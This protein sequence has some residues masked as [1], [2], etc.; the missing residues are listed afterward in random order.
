M[1]STPLIHCIPKFKNV[2]QDRTI[3]WTPFF[4]TLFFFTFVLLT[5]PSHYDSFC[6]KFPQLLW[7]TCCILA[8]SVMHDFLS[9]NI[10][11]SYLKITSALLLSLWAQ[12]KV[13]GPKPIGTA[14]VQRIGHQDFSAD[15]ELVYS[16]TCSSILTIPRFALDGL[17]ELANRHPALSLQF[18]LDWSC[19]CTFHCRWLFG[20]G[21][22]F[23]LVDS[24]LNGLDKF[25]S[26]WFSVLQK[27]RLLEPS[28]QVFCQDLINTINR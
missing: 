25:P 10:N 20:S 26:S 12:D 24:V 23:L 13:C 3:S 4:K 19:P 2:F 15:V 8:I 6:E 14:P 7:Y 1:K 17:G 28:E 16:R 21:I 22:D 27:G 5:M 11:A 9:T 18:C